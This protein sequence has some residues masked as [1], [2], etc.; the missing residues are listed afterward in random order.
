MKT[1]LAID[2]GGSTVRAVWSDNDGNIV[3]REVLEKNLN[4][5]SAGKNEVERTLRYLYEKN[6]ELDS[7]ILSMAGI[8]GQ[9]EY[10]DI[11]RIAEDIFPECT[12]RIFTDIEGAYFANFGL[13]SGVLVICGTGSI[14]LAKNDKNESVRAGGWG[15]LLGDE[16]SGFWLVKELFRR[17]LAYR[18][19][20]EPYQ[21][22]F[23]VFEKIFPE[24]PRDAFSYFYNPDLRKT[25][26]SLARK[27]LDL[28]DS[29]VIALHRSGLEKLTSQT[30]SV[31][32]RLGI[33]TGTIRIMG[34]IFE[35]AEACR[36]FRSTF[37]RY[38]NL[39]DLGVF[40]I[41][42]GEKDIAEAIARRFVNEHYVD[43]RKE[44]Q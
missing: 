17:Y 23:S 33:Q 11:T 4:Y 41:V 30:I 39:K 27:F 42:D 43:N 18:E 36:F 32:E 35:N 28:E 38:M 13:G 14:V 1:L 2:A 3:E 15:Y 21:G 19:Q 40:E 44:E 31:I 26:A 10:S 34:G 12:R 7:F 6:T 22:F 20:L 25:T 37:F 29:T 16:G 5:L 24:N 8:G 9:P